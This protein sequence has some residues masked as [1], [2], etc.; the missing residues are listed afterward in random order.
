MTT[1]YLARHGRTVL[2]ASGRL[3]G[4]LDPELDDVGRQ[5][6]VALAEALAPFHPGLVVTSPLRRAVETGRAVAEACHLVPETM[7]GFVDRDY[8]TWAGQPAAEVE[9]RWGSID[10]A[11]GVEP[12]SQVQARAIAALGAVA[13]KAGAGPAVVVA[14]DAV[15][16]L[17]LVALA[18]ERW[19]SHRDVPQPTGC[20]NVLVGAGRDWRVDR[21]GVLPEDA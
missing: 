6:A 17:V 7:A 10:Q 8:A 4:R 3:R 13:A 19:S 1:V 16:R 12:A 11:P 14:H 20:F 15:N 9:A 21:A 18:P 5:E 2:N